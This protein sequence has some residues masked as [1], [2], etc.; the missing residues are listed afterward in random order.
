MGIRET[1]G[2]L[3]G[4]VEKFWAAYPRRRSKGKAEKALSNALKVTTLETLLTSIEKRKASGEWTT[5][6]I[7]YIPYPATWLNAKGWEDEVVQSEE[8]PWRMR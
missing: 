3:D 1:S 4:S 5:D 6:R 7:K 2:P 8:T